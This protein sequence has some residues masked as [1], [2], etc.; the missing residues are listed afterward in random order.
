MIQKLKVGIRQVGAI[1]NGFKNLFMDTKQVVVWKLSRQQLNRNETEVVRVTFE[2]IGKVGTLFFLQLTPIIG[3][4]PIGFALTFPRLMLSRHFWTVDQT[5][6][7][8]REEYCERKAWSRKL[9]DQVFKGEKSFEANGVKVLPRNHLALLAGANAVYNSEIILQIW[10]G[11]WISDGLERRAD[12]IIIDDEMLLSEEEMRALGTEQ[13]RLALLR[14]GY[15]PHEGD[16]EGM[17]ERLGRWVK[18]MKVLRDHWS[19][20]E[21]TFKSMVLHIIAAREFAPKDC[22][23]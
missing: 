10:P 3:L 8:M 19:G 23:V 5:E 12:E 2:S 4:I 21:L 9:V 14:R 16:D 18:Q 7:F 17:K 20:D 6:L 11:A 22:S 1:S 15:D 13:L